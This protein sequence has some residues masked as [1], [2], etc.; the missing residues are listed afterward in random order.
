VVNIGNPS[1]PRPE[2]RISAARDGLGRHLRAG[3]AVLGVHASAM[4]LTT[5]A[6]WQTILGGRWVTGRSKHPPQGPSR[7]CVRTDAHPITAGL[8]DFEVF[9]E[10][11]SYLETG[12]DIVVLCEH[13]HDGIRHPVVWA[14]QSGPA[15]VVYDGLG[16][17]TRS[18]DSP[19]H[20]GLIQQSVAW[21]LGGI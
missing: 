12:A 20:V 13:E 8:G 5:M 15:R 9:D 3:G 10:R 16:H 19:G 18:Y 2:A 14:R 4:S 1:T 6:E 21:L 11:Y 17:D 7:I